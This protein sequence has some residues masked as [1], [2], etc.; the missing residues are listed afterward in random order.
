MRLEY[1]YLIPNELLP[2]LRAMMAPFVEADAH[3]GA[4]GYTV[5]SIYFD[6]ITFDYYHET[7]EGLGVRK[8]IR[9][10]GYNEC[11]EKN[12][13]FLEIKQKY[14]MYVTKSRAPVVYESVKDL[15]ISGDIERY[16]STSKDLPNALDDASRFFFHIYN[17]SLRP[18]ILIIYEREA[19]SSKFGSLRI[20]FDKNIR[21]SIYPSMDALFSED[22]TL[23]SIPHHF[24]LELKFRGGLPLWLRSIVG[25]LDIKRQTLS[26]YIICIDRHSMSNGFSRHSALACSHTLSFLG[27]LPHS[28]NS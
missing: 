21:S 2:K 24:V 15:F 7:T 9:T 25:T 16:V 23:Y 6:T 11:K 5:R 20:T 18:I 1:K 27:S 13:I 22:K 4:N 10:R 8:K 3:S 28:Q 14:G 19:Y 26:K 17:S 12:I